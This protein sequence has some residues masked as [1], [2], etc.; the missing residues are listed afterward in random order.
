MNGDRATNI[1]A[2]NIRV[3]TSDDYEHPY[4]GF[5]AMRGVF[6][7]CDIEIEVDTPHMDCLVDLY[8]HARWGSGP[9][10]FGSNLGRNRIRAVG[11]VT[12]TAVGN[13]MRWFVGT[14]YV[15]VN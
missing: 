15:P 3:R 1:Y 10:V 4:D 8:P 14:G 9:S 13:V 5:A 6:G 7:R 11:R 2:R 12:D